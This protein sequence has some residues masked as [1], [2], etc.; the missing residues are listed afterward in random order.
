MALITAAILGIGLGAKHA[1]E[2]DHIAAVCALVSRDTARRPDGAS[3]LDASPLGR[4][5]IPA[6]VL[7]ATRAGALWGAGHGAVVVLAGGALVATGA[8]VPTSIAAALDAAV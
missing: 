5:T 8:S 6:A 2:T 7:R 1:F 4:W 3:P